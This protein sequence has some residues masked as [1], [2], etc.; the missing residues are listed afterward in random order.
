MDKKP[1]DNR[2]EKPAYDGM[3]VR[4]VNVTPQGVLCSSAASTDGSLT[5]SGSWFSGSTNL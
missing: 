3:S 2:A 1:R 4:I 5:L